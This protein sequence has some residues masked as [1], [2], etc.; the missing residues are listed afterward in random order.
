LVIAN[1]NFGGGFQRGNRLVDAVTHAQRARAGLFPFHA[2]FVEEELAVVP[3]LP[4]RIVGEIGGRPVL[5]FAEH[6]NLSGGA[7]SQ[8]EFFRIEA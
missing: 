5:V 8:F 3:G 6:A 4:L 2:T 1:G 7:H